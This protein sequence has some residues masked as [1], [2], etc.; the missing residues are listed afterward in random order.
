MTDEG[1]LLDAH[2]WAPHVSSRRKSGPI[3]TK[4]ALQLRRL[5]GA[6]LVHR[7]CPRARSRWPL[8]ALDTAYAVTI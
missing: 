8:A 4:R 2:R 6:D 1:R 5:A 7:A 3:V